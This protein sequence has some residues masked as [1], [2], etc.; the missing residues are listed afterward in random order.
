M[1]THTLRAQSIMA[2]ESWEQECEVAGHMVSA[3]NK[4]QRWMNVG[5][6]LAFSFPF[7]IQ[8]ETSAHGVVPFTLRVGLSFSRFSLAPLKT[9]NV[10][11]RQFYI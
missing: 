11:P 5:A 9:R 10:T 2:R 1:L 4:K 8:S 6:Q 7:L 3:V